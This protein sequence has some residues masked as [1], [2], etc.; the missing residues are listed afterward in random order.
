MCWL[1]VGM[2]ILSGGRR[3]SRRKENREVEKSVVGKGAGV[4]EARNT[5]IDS[6]S[7]YSNFSQKSPRLVR[8]ARGKTQNSDFCPSL[9]SISGVIGWPGL[10]L[11]FLPWS[12]VKT[13]II[14][15]GARTFRIPPLWIRGRKHSGMIVF[16]PSLE[17]REKT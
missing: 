13:E 3:C 5:F 14:G 6:H 9:G 15:N 10:G 11:D 2:M 4:L 17:T 12:T 7:T 1:M 8:H 16:R